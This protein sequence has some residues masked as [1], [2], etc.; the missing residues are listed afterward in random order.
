MGAI[1]GN[2]NRAVHGRRSPRIGSVI[3]HMAKKF[4]QIEG[5]LHLLRRTLE[6]EARRVHSI[7]G[8]LPPPMDSAIGLITDSER[9]RRK[10]QQLARR[11]DEKGEF[12]RGLEL[13]KT[14]HAMAVQ[15]DQAIRRLGLTAAGDGDGGGFDAMDLYHPTTPSD[16]PAASTDPEPST[17]QQDA[18]QAT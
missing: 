18:A 3:A 8:A 6:A 9:V 12:D 17:Q 1:E 16:K 15:R 10:S 4:R 13:E 2:T 5:D 7:V 11:A 14:A